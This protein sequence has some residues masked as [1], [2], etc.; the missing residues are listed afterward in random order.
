MPL[1]AILLTLVVNTL[2]RKFAQAIMADLAGLRLRCIHIGTGPTIL[3][4]R[5]YDCE[6]VL[7]ALPIFGMVEVIPGQQG[8]RLAMFSF[9]AAGP[10]ANAVL[11]A[12]VIL[13]GERMADPELSKQTVLPAATVLVLSFLCSLWPSRVPTDGTWVASDGLR[14]LRSLRGE[15][16]PTFYRQYLDM[17]LHHFFGREYP[18]PR[19]SEAS[20]EVAWR[21]YQ[22]RYPTRVTFV[23]SRAALEPLLSLELG[24]PERVV[25]LDKLVTSGLADGAPAVDLDRWSAE[26]LSLAPDIATIRGT[27]GSVLIDIGRPAD[28]LDILQSAE[29]RGV[30]N[31]C[32]VHGFRAL[33]FFKLGNRESTDSEFAR[34]QALL[35]PQQWQ[36]TDGLR[37][38][39]R[40][41]KEIGRELQPL[42]TSPQDGL[43][44]GVRTQTSARQSQPDRS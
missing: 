43:R 35:V 7:K 39:E 40:I 2:A 27:R 10:L 14:M 41:S 18:L 13:I 17:T 33:G 25:V 4:T 15:A 8:R 26:A 12:L 28:G 20:D 21:I 23:E 36:G 22:Q 11:L 9:L 24:E 6:L 42:A 37:I 31:D 30:F 34:A 38:L 29:N 32:L 19:V 16:Q 5:R 44:A 1:L 3:S